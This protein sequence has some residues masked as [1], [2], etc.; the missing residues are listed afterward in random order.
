TTQSKTLL[1]EDQLP[2]GFPV[3]DNG[4]VLRVVERT[5]L[6]T[7]LCV[8][9]GTPDPEITWYKDLLP[10]DTGYNQGRIKQLRSA[11]SEPTPTQ[12]PTTPLTFHI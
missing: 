5:R 6:A 8:V 11:M 9:S 12:N 7:M 3:I 4:P 10:V 1:K 2:M